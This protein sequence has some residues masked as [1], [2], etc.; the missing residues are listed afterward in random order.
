MNEIGLPTLFFEG[1][2]AVPVRGRDIAAGAPGGER[3]PRLRAQPERHRL[4]VHH[5]G[6]RLPGMIFYELTQLVNRLTIPESIPNGS[7]ENYQMKL[8]V[9]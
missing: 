9:T 5:R 7:E 8:I 4:R 3:G 1:G 6:R 2:A